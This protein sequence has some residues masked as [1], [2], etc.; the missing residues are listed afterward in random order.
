M[1]Q[2]EDLAGKIF[3]HW[4]VIKRAENNKHGSAQWL[5]R[6]ECGKERV[7][8]AQGLKNGSSKSCG[9][10]K[11]D[12]NRTHGGKGTRLYECWRHMR[13]RCE[14]PKNQAYG[15]YGGRGISVCKDWHDFEKFKQWALANGY[16]DSL[17]IDR[18]DVDGDYEPNN[19][20]WVGSKVQMNNRRNTRHYEIDG[21]NLTLSEWSERTGIPRST[22]YNR[23]KNGDSFEE[24]IRKVNEQEEHNGR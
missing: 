13:Y 23:M 21:E 3:G 11:N 4:T 12:Y 10:H 24:A 22:I 18:I 6:C 16:E 8:R 9:C 14:N 1:A 7:V 2:L 20:R 15:D 19:C 5:C 17:T